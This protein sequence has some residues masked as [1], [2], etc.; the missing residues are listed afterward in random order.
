MN[1][2][3]PNLDATIHVGT[4]CS[5][6]EVMAWMAFDTAAKE[7]PGA[8]VEHVIAIAACK[9]ANAVRD[10]VT[11]TAAEAAERARNPRVSAAQL[12]WIEADLDDLGWEGFSNLRPI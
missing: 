6:M 7:N 9:A 4:I 10:I 11:A 8:T 5:A 1:A 3:D 2:Y 12:G